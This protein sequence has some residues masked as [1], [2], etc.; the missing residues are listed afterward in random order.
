M[1][2]AF[3]YEVLRPEDLTHENLRKHRCAVIDKKGNVLM[4][5]HAFTDCY[6]VGNSTAIYNLY[7]LKWHLADK[8]LIKIEANCKKEEIDGR[9]N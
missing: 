9:S 5:E 3:Y 2:N 6:T 8:T 4:I 1:K 7:G